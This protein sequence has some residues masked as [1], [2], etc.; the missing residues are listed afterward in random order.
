MTHIAIH[1]PHTV[2]GAI[3]SWTQIASPLVYLQ[4]LQVVKILFG[5][6]TEMGYENLLKQVLLTNSN[7]QQHKQ[8]FAFML[9]YG[10]SSYAFRNR[11]VGL[12]HIH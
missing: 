4:E 7:D 5:C 6:S 8:L 10:W 11:L 1:F 2:A 9:A 12:L 3:G